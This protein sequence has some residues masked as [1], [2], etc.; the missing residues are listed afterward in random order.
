[1]RKRGF[2]WSKMRVIRGTFSTNDYPKT[3]HILSD[4]YVVG[5]YFSMISFSK[6]STLQRRDAQLLFNSE[7]HL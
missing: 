7:F 6:T 4:I 1:M 3:K 5:K 2:L